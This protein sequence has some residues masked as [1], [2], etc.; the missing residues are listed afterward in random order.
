MGIVDDIIDN[1][2]DYVRNLDV[3]PLLNILF[4]PALVMMNA[5]FTSGY[6][7]S[8]MNT[9]VGGGL[10]GYG[11][12]FY[13]M[14]IL[15]LGYYLSE[16]LSIKRLLELVVSYAIYLGGSYMLLLATLINNPNFKAE[17]T[18]SNDFWEIRYL[19]T[20]ALV[21]VVAGLLKVVK[22]FVYHELFDEFQV[23]SKFILSGLMVNV[24]LC[25][26]RLVDEMVKQLNHLLTANQPQQMSSLIFFSSDRH[27]SLFLAFGL[28]CC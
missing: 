9:V 15:G 14:S 24:V 4:L 21:V 1:I 12:F 23:S 25:D 13:G 17:K 16:H 7:L 26:S 22:A 2:R 6:L 28:F 5:F 27:A 8:E 19:P 3:L 11:I 20:I 10:E 18:F